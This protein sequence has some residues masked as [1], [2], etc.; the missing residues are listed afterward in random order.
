MNSSVLT[1]SL[2]GRIQFFYCVALLRTVLHLLLRTAV[3]R[4]PPCDLASA[5]A[6]VASRRSDRGVNEG[7]SPRA[8]SRPHLALLLRHI[9]CGLLLR[10]GVRSPRADGGAR[11]ARGDPNSRAPTPPAGALSR[12]FA[13]EAS[14]TNRIWRGHQCSVRARRCDPRA[15]RHSSAL[16]PRSTTAY[17]MRAGCV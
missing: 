10:D 15:G 5:P 3:C 2:T 7:T 8:P 16:A 14:V 1:A 11:P 9:C 13:S 4:I 17:R 6:R 12:L